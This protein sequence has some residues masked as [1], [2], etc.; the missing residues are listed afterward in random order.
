MNAKHANAEGIG[1]EQKQTKS[2][3]PDKSGAM[4]RAPIRITANDAKYA[5]GTITSV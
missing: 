1:I 5:N 3:K 2:T 4:L